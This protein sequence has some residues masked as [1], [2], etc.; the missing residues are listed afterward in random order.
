MGFWIDFRILR[1]GIL[2]L[3]AN[4]AFFLRIDILLCVSVRKTVGLYVFFP[5]GNKGQPETK[6]IILFNFQ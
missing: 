3:S 6:Y 5:K 2:H 4:I 1:L